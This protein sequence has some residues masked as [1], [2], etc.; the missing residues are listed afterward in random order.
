MIC[1]RCHSIAVFGPTA[2]SPSRALMR[3]AECACTFDAYAV[4]GSR[5]EPATVR[6]AA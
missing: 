6:R 2:T 3:C 4:Y 5:E 1:P